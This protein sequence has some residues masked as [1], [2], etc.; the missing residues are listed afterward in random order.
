MSDGDE[1]QTKRVPTFEMPLLYAG[2]TPLT[3]FMHEYLP[4]RFSDTVLNERSHHTRTVSA[5]TQAR[6]PRTRYNLRTG[7]YMGRGMRVNFCGYC[8]VRAT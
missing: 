4:L 6:I 8:I 1:S 2:Y 7:T 5:C 3:K